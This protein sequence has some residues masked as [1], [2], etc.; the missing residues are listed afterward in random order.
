MLTVMLGLASEIMKKSAGRESG[1]SFD[2]FMIIQRKLL[3]LMESRSW[4]EQEIISDFPVEL[5]LDL[6]SL[7]KRG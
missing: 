4:Q 7:S 5:T 2:S 1:L 3:L 6:L